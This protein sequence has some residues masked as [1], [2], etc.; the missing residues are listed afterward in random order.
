MAAR[1]LAGI[2]YVRYGSLRGS[3]VGIEAVGANGEILDGLTTL[4]K[5]N[6]GYDL[7]Q[8]F[9]GA[10]GTLGIITK[11]ALVTQNLQS[12]TMHHIRYEPY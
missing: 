8:L 5:D 11:G 12:S 6:T 7:K 1:A 2:R 4:R 3:V 10:E 9:I